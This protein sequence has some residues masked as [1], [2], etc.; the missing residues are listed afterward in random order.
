MSNDYKKNSI[1][2]YRLVALPQCQRRPANKVPRWV[3][4]TKNLHHTRTTDRRRQL[5][6]RRRRS[7][8]ILHLI[9]LS[10]PGLAYRQS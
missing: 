6:P 1:T 9:R 4:S 8:L 5:R 10:A 3:A 7:A 2:I